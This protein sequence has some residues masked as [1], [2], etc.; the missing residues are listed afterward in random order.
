ME[1]LV[2]AQF[3][4]LGVPLGAGRIPPHL[5]PGLGVAGFALVLASFVRVRAGALLVGLAATN[6]T[7]RAWEWWRA[8]RASRAESRTV[9][10]D[11]P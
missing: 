7:L 10:P 5:A 4:F 3:L 1:F 2:A 11:P 6:V 9:R 8:C